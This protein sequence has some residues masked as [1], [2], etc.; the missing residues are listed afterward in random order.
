MLLRH[1]TNGNILK[2]YKENYPEEFSLIFGDNLENDYVQ[3]L[4]DFFMSLYG[5]KS[6]SNLVLNKVE[7]TNDTTEILNY[8]AFLLH[9]KKENCLNVLEITSTEY[10][11]KNTQTETHTETANN[12]VESIS[13]NSMDNT[14]NT[15]GYNTTEETPESSTNNTSNGSSS[16]TGNNSK[17][18]TINKSDKPIQDLI[19]KEITRKMT[20]NV[21][22]LIFN[23][24]ADI[25]FLSLYE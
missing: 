23:C 14:E 25:M 18:I 6:I 3:Y 20:D 7:N 15:F 5:N 10:D 24:Y 19:D 16:S 12:H 9:L 22:K 21:I 8:I 2:T 1:I 13:N 11:F 17:S 4:D